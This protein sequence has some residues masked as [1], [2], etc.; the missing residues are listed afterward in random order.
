MTSFSLGA[1]HPSKSILFLDLPLRDSVSTYF[2]T[3][4]YSLSICSI[5]ASENGL[6]HLTCG[7]S[8]NCLHRPIFSCELGIG[9]EVRPPAAER[10][11]NP[12]VLGIQANSVR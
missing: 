8:Q 6:N 11:S 9:V 3:A 12:R 2:A 5:L 4:R 10:I 1:S 7:H